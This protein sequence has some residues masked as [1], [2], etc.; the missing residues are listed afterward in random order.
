MAR[1]RIAQGWQALV[2]TVVLKTLPVSTLVKHFSPDNGCPT[3]ELYSMA[4][5]ASF[6]MTGL[7]DFFGWNALEADDA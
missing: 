5:L 1:K 2:R 6:S 3:K 7:A 4:R